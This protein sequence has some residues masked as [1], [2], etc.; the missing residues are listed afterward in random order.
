MAA[1]GIDEATRRKILGHGTAQVSDRY[2][3]P[4]VGRIAEQAKEIPTV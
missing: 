2:Y 1:A 3:H 4:N